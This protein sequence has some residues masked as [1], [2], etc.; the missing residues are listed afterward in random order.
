MSTPLNE[1][2]RT[3]TNGNGREGD[4]TRRCMGILG[5]ARRRAWRR[6]VGHPA[7]TGN[8][9]QL[10]EGSPGN[11]EFSYRTGTCMGGREWRKK[12]R[13]QGVESVSGG[14]AED[15][16]DAGVTHQPM[17]ICDRFDSEV[18]CSM[19]LSTCAS[20]AR[21]C[22]GLKS[23]PV[24]FCWTRSMTCTARVLISPTAPS[25]KRVERQRQ[26]SAV[27]WDPTRAWQGKKDA[28]S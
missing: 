15:E 14:S 25:G 13:H 27:C 23:R 9:C 19:S 11:E 5:C 21:L 8:K 20:T 4:R 10:R 1:T 12:C 2:A 18:A 28:P 16:K 3:T 24:S 26:G 17:N 6:N 7:V 22:V